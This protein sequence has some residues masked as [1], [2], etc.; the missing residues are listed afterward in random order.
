MILVKFTRSGGPKSL[1]CARI[2]VL[3]ARRL[4]PDSGCSKTSGMDACVTKLMLRFNCGC[5]CCS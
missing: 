5:Y 1:I 2:V 4:A 3:S